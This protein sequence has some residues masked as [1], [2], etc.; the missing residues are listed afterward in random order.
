MNKDKFMSEDN[1]AGTLDALEKRGSEA[2]NNNDKLIDLFFEKAEPI[3]FSKHNPNIR[4]EIADLVKIVRDS[5]I[6]GHTI[7]PDGIYKQMQFES[8]QFRAEHPNAYL[9]SHKE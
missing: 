4:D 9:S 2:M 8:S 1:V 6:D 7:V 3:C 5:M